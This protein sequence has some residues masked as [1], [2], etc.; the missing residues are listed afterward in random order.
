VAVTA[1]SASDCSSAACGRRAISRLRPN[2]LLNSVRAG[3]Q[4][5]FTLRGV[6]TQTSARTRQPVAMYVDEVYKSVGAVQA[7]QT[8]DLD[9]V[10]V[11][12]GPQGPCTQERDRGAI[13]F[14]TKIEPDAYDGYITAG[15]ATTVLFGA[16]AVAVGDRQRNRL[17]AR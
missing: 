12:R 3:G 17:R 8:Y 6:T 7:L 2:L 14:Y 16:G 11:L 5:T 13:S 10:E 1:I 4:P 15:A 9:R